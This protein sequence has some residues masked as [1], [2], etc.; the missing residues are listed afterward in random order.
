MVKKFPP[1][2]EMKHQF[3]FGWTYTDSA[4]LLKYN[5]SSML[6]QEEKLSFL[7]I[8]IAINTDKNRVSV[9]MTE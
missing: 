2:L 3:K 6:P 8:W 1:S 5:F 4:I 7:G 9:S